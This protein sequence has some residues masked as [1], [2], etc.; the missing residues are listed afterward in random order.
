MKNN[1][2]LV[3]VIAFI[4]GLA[5]GYNLFLGQ[6]NNSC[7]KNSGCEMMMHRMPNGKTMSN[8]DMMS[9]DGMMDH[10]T[11][12]LEGKTGDEFD[13]TFIREMIVH[14][15]GAVKMAEMVLKNSKRTDLIKLA[16]DIISAQTKEINMMKV[17]QETWFR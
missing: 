5:I 12:S 13:R 1:L 11:A 17:W 7:M 10:M 9:M 3:G 6:D 16:N 2:I 4:L 14:H 15:E 8:E